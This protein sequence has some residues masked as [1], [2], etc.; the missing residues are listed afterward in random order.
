MNP[1]MWRLLLVVIVGLSGWL[2]GGVPSRPE[3]VEERKETAPEPASEETGNRLRAMLDGDGATE[4]SFIDASLRVLAA[5]EKAGARELEKA[6]ALLQD[7]RY[8][9]D[10]GFDL[11]RAVLERRFKE[12]FPERYL[13]SGLSGQETEYFLRQ[14]GARDPREAFAAAMATGPEMLRVLRVRAVL[15]GVRI[16]HVDVGLELLRGI[17]DAE[18]RRRV[19]GDV[20]RTAAYLHPETYRELAAEFPDVSDAIHRAAFEQLARRR[21]PGWARRRPWTV[22][23]FSPSMPRG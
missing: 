3:V 5:I 17:G 18:F 19:S 8:K 16:D 22:S 20:P 10:P 11:L 23:V 2:A 12:R 21:S 4:P 6:R 15:E 9:L 13:A 1:L 7:E 14:W